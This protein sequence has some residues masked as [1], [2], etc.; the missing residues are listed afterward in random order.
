MHKLYLV[1][2]LL[3]FLN[4]DGFAEKYF[5]GPAGNW[6][7]EPNGRGRC[8]NEPNERDELVVDREI[9][10]RGPFRTRGKIKIESGG[11]L[12]ISNGQTGSMEVS[13]V[14]EVERG[15]VLSVQRNLGFRNNSGIDIDEGGSVLV[16]G[17]FTN[18][19]NSNDVKIDGKLEIGGDFANGNNGVIHGNGRIA[20]AGSCDNS[21]E[22]FGVD[23]TCAG[24][25]NLTL[26]VELLFFDAKI[27]GNAVHLSWATASE[28]NFDYFTVERSSN[29][30]TFSAIGAPVKGSGN[31][32]HILN[33]TFIDEVP[34]SGRSYYRLK[35]VDFDG[36]IE[37]H[38]IATVNYTG[39]MEYKVF[40]NPS[41]GS[42]VSINIGTSPS[43]N[44]LVKIYNII[45]EEVFRARYLQGTNNY[46]FD[47]PLEKGL[48]II[49]VEDGESKKQMKL[50][51]N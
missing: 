5:S 25:S 34:F 33:Y 16:A 29:A 19:N 28:D 47:R 44:S 10:L 48:Y 30:K 7:T 32:T 17:D 21:G 1:F 15:G 13:G 38:P 11:E 50:T 40:P 45:G 31:A 42:N 6:C 22:V 37:Y 27:V 8:V 46:N 4:F 9:T 43:K 12:T 3:I 18:Y 39:E 51:V 35:A 20:V 49:I 2:F 24:I 26:P 41:G 14:L 23:N 36:T